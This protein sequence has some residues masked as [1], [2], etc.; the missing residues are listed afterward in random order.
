MLIYAEHITPRLTYTVSL[1]FTEMLGIE[2]QLSTN[3]QDVLSST[4]P[5][6]NYSSHK[7]TQGFHIEPAGLLYENSIRHITPSTGWW[8]DIPTLFPSAGDIPFDLFSAVFYLV[9]RYEEYLPF[10]ADEHQRFPAAE[11]FLFRHH[12]LDRPLV[13]LWVKKLS[14]LLHQQHPGLTRPLRFAHILTIDMDV[15]FKYLHKG[16]LR[17]A[18][19]LA[20]DA[21]RGNFREWQERFNVWKGKQDPFDVMDFIATVCH[22][23]HFSP[24]VFIPSGNRGTYDKNLPVSH[25]A[26]QRVI[27]EI[28]RFG[29]C[30]L[31][32][33]YHAAFCKDLLRKEKFSLEN[34][35]GYPIYQ[36]RQHYLR[37]RFPDTYRLLEEV[38][39]KEDY[40]LGFH[41]HPGFRAGIA[42]PFYFYDLCRET[43]TSLRIYPLMAM[44]RTFIRYLQHTPRQMVVYVQQLVETLQYTGGILTTL[45]HNDVLSL[46]EWK[47][48]FEKTLAL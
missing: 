46:P 35:A 7:M 40:S 14:L 32:P 18:G 33:S 5:C 13:N 47:M 8:D 4:G 3:Q 45:F 6:I 21:L 31:H 44:D 26:M 37:V 30:G 10:R 41:D 20:K 27:K 29:R 15:P 22:E 39:I 28:N 12:L 1:V 9:S 43:K 23:Q 38:G 42:F 24:L 2:V 48:A 19:G 34:I 17:T 11:S 25:P 16:F 36:S